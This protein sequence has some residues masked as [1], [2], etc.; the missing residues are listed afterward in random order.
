MP[1][2]K[3]VREFAGAKQ[4]VKNSAPACANALGCCMQQK[5]A[6][7]ERFTCLGVALDFSSGAPDGD[8]SL[9]IDAAENMDAR[10]NAERAVL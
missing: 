1:P 5:R 7:Y 8:R 10:H 4:K 6:H 3:A 9:G 2:S